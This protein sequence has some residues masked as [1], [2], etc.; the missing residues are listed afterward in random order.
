MFWLANQKEGEE[1]EYV[2]VDGSI[3]LKCVSNKQD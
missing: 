2:D 3:I 1:F